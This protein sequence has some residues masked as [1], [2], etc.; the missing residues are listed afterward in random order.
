MKGLGNMN[1][2]SLKNLESGFFAPYNVKDI[3]I[4]KTSNSTTVLVSSNNDRLRAFTVRKNAT[5]KT[6]SLNK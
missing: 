2:K 6:L 1:F 3:Q 4:I 5:G